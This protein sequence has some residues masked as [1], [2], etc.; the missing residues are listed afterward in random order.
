MKTVF[1]M[2]IGLSLMVNANFTRDNNKRIIKDSVTGLEWQDD[3]N[4]TG[5]HT[6]YEAM[7]Y[8][9]KLNSNNYKG[10][11]DWR[12][13]NINELA[14]ILDDTKSAPSINSIFKYTYTQNAGYWS[15]TTFYD[16]HS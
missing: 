4:I 5:E 15:S 1:L 6:W 10:Y 11:T 13:P 3:S 9:D 16:N 8:C 2:I 14:S 7:D 12:L